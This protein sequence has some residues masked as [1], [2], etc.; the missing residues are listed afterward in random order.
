[1]DWMGWVG[2]VGWPL[3][4]FFERGRQALMAFRK[5]SCTFLEFAPMV[6]LVVMAMACPKDPENID[7]LGAQYSGG[8][9]ESMLETG[10]TAFSTVSSTTCFKLGKFGIQPI[11]YALAKSVKDV[12]K[13][14]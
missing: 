9:D 14:L 5:S 3:T 8:F 4:A 10:S 12:V 13:I 1:M 2:W 11:G 7:R 6:I